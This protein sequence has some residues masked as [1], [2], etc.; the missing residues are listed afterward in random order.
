MGTSVTWSQMESPATRHRPND[1]VWAPMRG[2]FLLLG[3]RSIAFQLATWRRTGLGLESRRRRAR[4]PVPATR[5]TLLPETGSV[6]VATV[7]QQPLDQLQ[8]RC[9]QLQRVRSRP[10][11]LSRFKLRRQTRVKILLLPRTKTRDK[12]K[13][14]RKLRIHQ[15]KLGRLHKRQTNH[16]HS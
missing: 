15:P 9:R 13:I 10:R 7:R 3:R 2:N 11:L 16:H 1:G 4:M 8:R 6:L 14:P 12:L 5:G